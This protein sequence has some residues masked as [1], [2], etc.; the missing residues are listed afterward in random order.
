MKSAKIY[1]A[2]IKKV[3]RGG[4]DGLKSG[5]GP[6]SLLKLNICFFCCYGQNEQSRSFVPQK[7]HEGENKR[8]RKR[9]RIV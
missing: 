3:R 6:D 9:E 4:T 2:K 8:N 7:K 1:L 5:W